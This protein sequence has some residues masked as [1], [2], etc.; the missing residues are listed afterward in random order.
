M[1]PRCTTTLQVLAEHVGAQAAEL[2]SG[3]GFSP[4]CRRNF[5]TDLSF[6]SAER[7][8]PRRLHRVGNAL[9]STFL[10]KVSQATSW[11]TSP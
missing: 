8:T 1:P 5:L 3:K 6:S 7:P 2:V 9:T 4:K 11:A 10:M